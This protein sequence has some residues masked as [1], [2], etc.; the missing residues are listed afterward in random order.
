MKNN[1]KFETD[2][3][4]LL[5][6]IASGVQPY[7]ANSLDKLKNWLV[8]LHRENIVKINH[9]V[10]ELV[11]AKY[12]IEKEYNI[13][14]EYPLNEIL[15]CDLYG[16]KGLGNLVVEIE[17]GFIPPENALAPLTYTTARLAS[18]I[19]RYS[20]FTGKF[21][22]GVPPHYILPFPNTFAK[23]PRM[24]TKQEIEVIKALCD[25][26]YQ[27]PPVTL[28]GIRNARIQ[29]I[30]IIDVDHGL[31]QEIDP[32]TYLDRAMQKGVSYNYLTAY[33]G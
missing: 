13:Q 10:M 19:V 22:L 3:T 21:A 30:Y 11:C 6:R 23:P 15:T 26:Y 20:G 18:K 14:L 31:V 24:R 8:E 12:L 29:E 17:T 7:V 2:L 27:K 1:Q 28:E 25:A 33:V 32:E 5:D 4:T 16:T 9:S